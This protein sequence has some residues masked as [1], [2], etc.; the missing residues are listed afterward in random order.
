M[1]MA[2]ERN[3]GSSIPLHRPRCPSDT[4]CNGELH[5]KRIDYTFES[6][7]RKIKVPDLE[8]WQCDQCNE[9]F[10]PAEANERIDLSER[11]SGRFLV[12]VPPEL[13]CQLTHV[14][15]EHHRS[16]NQEITFL[17]SQALRK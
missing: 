1:K 14:A 10:F 7:G 3:Q 5:R 8:V 17:L 9:I 16:L 6:N 11:F 13:H 2:T 4:D 15:K 12:R